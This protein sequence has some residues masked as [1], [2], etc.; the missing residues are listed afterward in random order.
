MK[1]VVAVFNQEK[2]PVGSFFVIVQLHRLNVNSS[3]WRPVITLPVSP[4]RT[5]DRGNFNRCDSNS[6]L[7]IHR[8][9]WKPGT[10]QNSIID[11][12]NA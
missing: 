11:L 8:G 7:L 2:A 4:Y 5:F 3:T 6:A 12:G 9:R 1:A 10:E